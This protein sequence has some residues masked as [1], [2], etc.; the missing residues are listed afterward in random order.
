MVNFG[1]KIK[2]LRTQRNLTQKQLAD[3][4]GV[5]VSAISSYEAGNRYPSYDV[6]ISLARI[7][8]VS[9]DYLLGLENLKTV[10]VSGLEDRQINVILQM[11]DI[12]KEKNL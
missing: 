3:L 10:D 9:T 5:A 8:H 7:F 6:L 4:S 12:M 2:S 11:I 1:E